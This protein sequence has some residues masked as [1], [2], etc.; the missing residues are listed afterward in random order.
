MKVC[1]REFPSEYWV[2]Q[3]HIASCWVNV[4]ENVGTPLEVLGGQDAAKGFTPEGKE[5]AQ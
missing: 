1:L 2:A 4:L 3:D 5:A